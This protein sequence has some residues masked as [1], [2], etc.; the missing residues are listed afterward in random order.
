MKKKKLEI[1]LQGV[2][3]YSNP[4]ATLEQYL[5]PASIAADILFM[6]YSF[7][8]IEGKIVGDLGA[9]TGMFSIGACILGARKVYAVEFDEDAVNDM[10]TNL[11]NFGCKSVDIMITDIQKAE[12][13]VDTVIQNPPFGCQKKHAD[14]P[15]LIKSL[16][17]GKVIYTIHNSQTVRFIR[18]K[19]MEM[20]GNITHE[21][22]YRFKIPMLFDF[23]THERI[24][25][26]VS[27]LRIVKQ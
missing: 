7:G 21:I 24:F 1:I 16:E 18:K 23:H 22:H 6:A 8:D 10:R 15:F 4:K 13:V 9:G 2:N 11:K 25:T 19:I 27:M 20:G 14:M 5:T 12:L 26:D 17:V 3:G